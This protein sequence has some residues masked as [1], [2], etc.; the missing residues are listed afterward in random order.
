MQDYGAYVVADSAWN[1][2]TIAMQEGVSAEFLEEF[3]FN[4]TQTVDGCDQENGGCA[5]LQEVWKIY[6]MLAV[7]DNNSNRSVGG[8][9]APRATPAPALNDTSKCP[10]SSV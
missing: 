1:A 9:G 5:F 6:G 2:T 7:V 10:L 4:F 3:G 8:G